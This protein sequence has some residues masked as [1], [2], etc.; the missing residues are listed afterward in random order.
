VFVRIQILALHIFSLTTLLN[1]HFLLL[2]ISQI[3]I[4]ISF[5]LIFYKLQVTLIQ[6][7]I[8]I[9]SIDHILI[10]FHAAF[11]YNFHFLFLAT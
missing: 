7:L 8:Q 9:I 11:L 2:T 5:L 6:T 1:V 10:L 4:K 3:Q